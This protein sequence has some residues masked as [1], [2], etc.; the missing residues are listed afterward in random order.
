MNVLST[1]HD[2]LGEAALDT[3][4]ITQSITIDGIDRAARCLAG[5]A[6]AL[7]PAVS[8]DPTLVGRVVSGPAVLVDRQY[9]LVGRLLGLH[10]EFAQRLFAVLGAPGSNETVGDITPVP[11]NVVSLQNVRPPR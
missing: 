7:P 9:A 2:R 8:P 4:R 10:R 11:A 6:R 5:I 1:V 3:T